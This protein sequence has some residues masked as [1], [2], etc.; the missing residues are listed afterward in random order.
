MD[1]FVSSDSVNDLKD[2]N[3]VR[4][5]CYF[6]KIIISINYIGSQHSHL[7]ILPKNCL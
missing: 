4:I 5:M 1:G 7:L 2:N 3:K 6:E